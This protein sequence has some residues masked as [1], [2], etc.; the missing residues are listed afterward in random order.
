MGLDGKTVAVA[1]GLFVAGLLLSGAI[2]SFLLVRLPADYFSGTRRGMVPLDYHPVLRILLLVLKNVLGY[3]FIAG[4]LVMSIPGV[5]GQGFL[6]IFIGILLVD[7]PGKYRL[8]RRLVRIPALH[9]G[10]DWIRRRF[11]KPPLVLESDATSSE[12]P[13]P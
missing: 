2:I 13:S 6:T 5:P 10:I 11:G 7:F 1:A 4:G 12:T 3:V 8:E 9:R